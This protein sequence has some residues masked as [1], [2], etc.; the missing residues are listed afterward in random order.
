MFSL[1]QF[2]NNS[3]F[4]AVTVSLTNGFTAI[5]AGFSIF[6]ILGFM[7]HSMDVPV[8]D[9]VTEGPGLAFIAYP[10]VNL[11]KYACMYVCMCLFVG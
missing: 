10:E 9:V 5:F 7:A 8:A 1:L 3:H 6:A 11:F 4:D 2:T